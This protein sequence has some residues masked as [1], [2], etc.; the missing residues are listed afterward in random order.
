MHEDYEKE[1]RN[2]RNDIALVYLDENDLPKADPV[3]LYFDGRPDEDDLV[4]IVGFGSTEDGDGFKFKELYL[5][6]IK[7]RICRGLFGGMLNTNLQFC[8]DESGKVGCESSY[9]FTSFLICSHP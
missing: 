7:S 3:E 5:R 6:L 4:T 9:V 1:Q 8:T 2:V